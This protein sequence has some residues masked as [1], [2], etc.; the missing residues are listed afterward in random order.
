MIFSKLSSFRG[1]PFY[2]A[3]IGHGLS[4]ASHPELVDKLYRAGFIVSE[5]LKDAMLKVD[6]GRFIPPGIV[7]CP[8]LNEPVGIARS[9]NLSSRVFHSVSTPQF[10]AQQLSLIEENLGQGK[11]AI[12]VGTGT[13]YIAAVMAEMGCDAVVATEV[14]ERM[15]EIAEK[16]LKG[17][18][19]VKVEYRKV[20]D[21]I[22]PGV[23][24]YDAIVVSPVISSVDHVVSHLNA[25]GLASIA[26]EK[27]AEHSQLCRVNRKDTGEVFVEKLMHVACE[28]MV[29]LEG[30][31]Q[32]ESKFDVEAWLLEWSEKFTRTHG[33]KPTRLDI[34]NDP[35]ARIMFEAFSSK[36]RYSPQM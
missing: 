4:S 36:R 32:E 1:D 15:F 31:R 6:R 10:H 21:N 16:N 29:T 12:D 33:R 3:T 7:L 5:R 35:Q 30:V 26:L 9:S 2:Q 19:N 18:E 13:G 34:Q 8:Y 27:V 11:V 17:Y 20:G 24:N 28:K 23:L 14:D 22:F 25:D